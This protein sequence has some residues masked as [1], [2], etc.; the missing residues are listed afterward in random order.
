MLSHSYRWSFSG[1]L[2]V[3]LLVGCQDMT[4]P[5]GL[6]GNPGP[7]E[8]DLALAQAE[9][10]DELASQAELYAQRVAELAEKDQPQ[11]QPQA[12][13][14]QQMQQILW[15]DVGGQTQANTELVTTEPTVADTQPLDETPPVV[16]AMEAMS[17][18]P[19]ESQTAQPTPVAAPPD[20]GT[21]RAQ[22]STA[23]AYTDMLEAV[24]Y[25]DDSNLSKAVAAATLAPIGPHGELDWSLLSKLSPDDQQRIK[26]YH[27][28]VSMMH[29]QLLSGDAE[30]DREAVAGRLEELYGS[31][32]VT[33][34]NIRLCEKVMGYGVYDAFPD[35]TFVAGREQ[36][37]IVYVELD[38]FEP[39]Q[40]QAGGDYEVRLRQELELYESN[41][42]EVWS[43]EPV[44][45]SDVSKNKRRDFFV[46]QLVTLPAQLRMGQYHMKVRVYD[47]NGGTRDEASLEIRLVADGALVKEDAR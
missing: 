46:V 20:T 24:R 29:A 28:A 31:Q 27:R 33:I 12:Q 22:P 43:H 3:G 30:L 10:G 1:V 41:G 40:N 7:T 32:P 8:A 2:I 23:Q 5:T 13:Q 42:F 6:D 34:R 26:N 25:S 11:P 47:E 38:N 21:I 44:I 45:I 37:L 36:K 15:R 35:N 17:T 19:G 39:L 14:A 16:N 4:L 18:E 9:P